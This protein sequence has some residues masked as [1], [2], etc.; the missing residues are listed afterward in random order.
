MEYVQNNDLGFTL[1]PQA[2]YPDTKITDY[3]YTN[4]SNY[5][6]NSI[7]YRDF[8]SE[9]NSL[10]PITKEIS[11]SIT[12]KFNSRIENANKLN[13]ALEI[14]KDSINDEAEDAAFY[15][16]LINQAIYNPDNNISNIGIG[17]AIPINLVK[18]YLKENN[19]I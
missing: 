15:N 10:D 5:Q 12:M 17:F 14:I 16:M 19:S 6:K 2:R 8:S 11:N 7:V 4:N 18:E 1:Y 9:D 13:D 3:S